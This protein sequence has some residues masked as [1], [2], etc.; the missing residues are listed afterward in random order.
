[1]WWGGRAGAGA[2]AAQHDSADVRQS[3]FALVGDIGRTAVGR[4]GPMLGPVLQLCGAHLD[5]DYV[6]V[7]NN[8]CWAAGEIVVRVREGMGPVVAELL[9]RVAGLVVRP[10][11]H[12]SL[13]EN[14]AIT[15]G[16]FA[17]VAPAVVA[18]RSQPPLPAQPTRPACAPRPRAAGRAWPVL[19]P[20]RKRAWCRRG[21]G[22]PRTLLAESERARE[23]ERETDRQTDR[24]TGRQTDRQ[25]DR[26][27]DRDREFLYVG[28]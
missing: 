19:E 16:R 17:L 23:R 8:A 9:G 20:D 2:G 6:S 27:G 10:Q 3:G 4:L 1:M 28:A 7:C 12:K 26:E 21:G 22:G 15:L 24:Q 18:P 13:L 5:P 14:C 25:T 11:L